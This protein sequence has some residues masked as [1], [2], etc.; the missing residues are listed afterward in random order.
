[1]SAR[2]HQPQEW[3]GRTLRARQTANG[4]RRRLVRPVYFI[5][6]AVAIAAAAF[7][8][9]LRGTDEPTKIETRLTESAPA[10]SSPFEICD[11]S[12]QINCVFEGDTIVHNRIKIRLEDIDAP[13]IRSYKCQAEYE[14]GRQATLRLLELLNLGP[15]D[16]VQVGQRAVDRIGR[17]L[18]TLYR[19]RKS[20]G[21]QLVAEGLAHPWEGHSHNWCG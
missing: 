13:S 12:D 11:G 6:I 1:M 17:P 2:S 18:R 15:F 8:Q 16:V 21:M 7:G 9:Y 19:D 5:V 3:Q 20:I 4:P 10:T 14:L